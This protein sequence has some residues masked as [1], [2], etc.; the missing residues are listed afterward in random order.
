MN[1]RPVVPRKQIKKRYIAIET[2]CLFG[3][4][5]SAYL[6][7]SHYSPEPSVFCMFLEQ[8]NCD[9]VNKSVYSEI[10]GLPVALLGLLVYVV[11]FFGALGLHKGYNFQ[12]L[13]AALR[14]GR[15]LKSL[16][17]LTLIAVVF[18]LYLTY[19]EFFVLFTICPFCAAHQIN[20]V[21]I[22]LIFISV[23]ITAFKTKKTEKL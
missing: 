7:Y 16:F 5:L 4:I 9:I 10:F 3:V 18:S 1:Q 12:H 6:V 15:V 14:P 17:W 2:L 8:I 21:V 11:L 22:L 23:L 13:H 20:I 19:I